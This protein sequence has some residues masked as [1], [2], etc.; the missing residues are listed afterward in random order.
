MQ[1]SLDEVTR[2]FQSLYLGS[3]EEK[4]PGLR[5]TERLIPSHELLQTLERAAPFAVVTGKPVGAVSL[6]SCMWAF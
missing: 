6:S 2:V 1:V 5:D 3:V 4:R